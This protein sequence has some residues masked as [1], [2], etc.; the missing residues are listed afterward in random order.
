LRLLYVCATG[1]THAG[2]AQS[3]KDRPELYVGR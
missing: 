3:R 2:V 1:V